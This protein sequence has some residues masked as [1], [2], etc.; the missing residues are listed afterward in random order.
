[1]ID[2]WG[3]LNWKIWNFQQGLVNL[4]TMTIVQKAVL[5]LGLSHGALTGLANEKMDHEAHP[6]VHI[7]V[8]TS[9]RVVWRGHDYCKKWKRANVGNNYKHI[10]NSTEKILKFMKIFTGWCGYDV[11]R[12][13]R[14][15]KWN[16]SY[17]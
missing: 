4:Q 6:L 16:I 11:R 1:M 14:K 17:L 7:N 15:R 3:Q 2:K 10:L 12:K 5:D 13:K 9:K 8:R